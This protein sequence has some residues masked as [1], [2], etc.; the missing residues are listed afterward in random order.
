MQRNY[1]LHVSLTVQNCCTAEKIVVQRRASVRCTCTNANAQ[2]SWVC[3][4]CMYAYSIQSLPLDCRCAIDYGC[5][6]FRHQFAIFF[7]LFQYIR[8]CA[9]VRVC[10][11]FPH[12][13][14]TRMY[15]EYHLL[16][17]SLL[18]IV[19]RSKSRSSGN[20]NNNKALVVF[21]LWYRLVPCSS[22]AQCTTMSMN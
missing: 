15:S 19:S 21:W 7:T 14:N 9:R 8:V 6:L 1:S 11:S 22:C 13:P 3:A 20:N 4:M 12:L 18:E 10:A 16:L 2:I 17:L 5:V